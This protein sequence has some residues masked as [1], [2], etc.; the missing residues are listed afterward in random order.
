MYFQPQQD[1]NVGG[2]TSKTQFQYTLRDA[3]VDELNTWAPRVVEKLKALPELRDVTSD[4]ESTSPALNLE[5]DRQ[6]ASRFGIQT[7]AINAALY[8]A[9]GERQVTQFYTQLSQYKVIIEV[10]PELQQDSSTLDKLF[11]K[12]PLTGGQVPL[13][14]LVKLNAS[15]TKPLSVN[16]LG[17]YPAVTISFNLAP[18]IALGQA[19]EAVERAR[20]AMGTRRPSP[21][22][23]R[24]RPRPSSRR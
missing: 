4:Q 12:S 2:L 17:Q 1:L 5:I 3:D 14:S 22:A 15:S 11:L 13:S 7:Q 18:N 20:D 9:F 21:A 19:V 24:A 6:A 23:S 16:H 10:S 8:N